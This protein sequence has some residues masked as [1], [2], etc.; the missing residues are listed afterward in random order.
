MRWVHLL[1]ASAWFG[2]VLVI[3]FVLIPALSGRVGQAR[4]EF[5]ATVFP[6]VFRLA[7]VLSATTALTG[8]ALLCLYT[9]GNWRMLTEGRFGH[10]ILV[11]GALGLVLTLFHFFM[12]NKLARRVGIGRPDTPDQALADVHVKLKVVPRIGLAVITTIYFLMMV[13]ARGT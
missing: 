3:N 5:L 13:A 8:A 11:G 10:F 1:S 9:R 4:R 12:E 7:S 2:E 6:K